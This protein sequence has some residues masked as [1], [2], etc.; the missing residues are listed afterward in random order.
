MDRVLDEILARG[1][2]ARGYLGLGLQPVE[3]PDHQKG[4]I[5]L[6]LEPAGPAA[7]AGAM[8]GDILVK[9]DPRDFQTRVDQARAALALAQS[10][11]QAAT[12]NVPL[13]TA[14]TSTGTTSAEADAEHARLAYNQAS[15]ADWGRRKCLERSSTGQ[16]PAHVRL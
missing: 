3:L 7:K 11:S 14:T 16:P 13:T 4:L 1:H 12:A 15:T 10:Q 2:V 5:V 8:I 9:L 6:S